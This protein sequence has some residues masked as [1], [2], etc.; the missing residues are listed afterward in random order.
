[1][2]SDPT[3]YAK[4]FEEAEKAVSGIKNEKL[5]EIAFEKLLNLLLKDNA[6]AGDEEGEDEKDEKPKSRK[7][8]VKKSFG[9][10]GAKPS[11]DGPKAWLRELVEEGFFKKPKSS[12]EIREELET[13][14]HHLKATDL[15][16]PLEALCHE[17]LLR[18]KKE[19][20]DVGG[21]AV[22]HWVNW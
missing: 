14:S 13:R 11:K 10:G 19:A 9:K 5:K 6:P 12:S 8:K 1:M 20:S 17:K 7:A 15:T 21:K 18:R 3:N 22:L 4:L 16:K 2:T